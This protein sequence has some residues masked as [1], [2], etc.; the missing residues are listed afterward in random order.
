MAK[1]LIKVKKVMATGNSEDYHDGNLGPPTNMSLNTHS[2][3]A[4]SLSDAA[5][6][7]ESKQMS[8]NSGSGFFTNGQNIIINGGTFILNAVGRALPGREAKRLGGSDDSDAKS[9]QENGFC[10]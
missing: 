4:T 7:L 1:R 8:L 5:A 6:S 9:H 3:I 10:P 2:P